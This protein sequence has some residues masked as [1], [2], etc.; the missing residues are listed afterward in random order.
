MER[1]RLREAFPL[2]TLS[3]GGT[4]GA[5]SS[6]LTATAVPAQPEFDPRVLGLSPA[7]RLAAAALQELAGG[8]A[9]CGPGRLPAVQEPKSLRLA[10]PPAGAP[11]ST[12]AWRRV[13]GS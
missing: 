10:L 2:D 3:A 11:F 5:A 7:H 8:D 4:A 6:S 13:I 9:W 1:Q 12:D